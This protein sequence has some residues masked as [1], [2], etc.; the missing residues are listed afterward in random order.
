MDQLRDVLERAQSNGAALGHFN[1]SDWIL[2][3]AV[4]ASAQEL[5]V[6]VIVGTSEGERE[7]LG[8]A[9]IAALV[10]SLREEES[11]HLSECRPHAFPGQLDSG[12]QSWIRLSCV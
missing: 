3:K 7:F 2:L 1:I 8:V 5:R 10:K 9:Q 11:F 12:G 4:F 6:P